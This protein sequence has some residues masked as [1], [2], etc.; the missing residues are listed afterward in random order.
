[1]I[2]GLDLDNSISHCNNVYNN[3]KIPVLLFNSKYNQTETPSN[4]KRIF[5]WDEAYKEIIKYEE[6]CMCKTEN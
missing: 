1:M 3:A 2:I 5:N 6:E 4:I